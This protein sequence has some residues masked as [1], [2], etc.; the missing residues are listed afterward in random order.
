MF[1]G[2]AWWGISALFGCS[3]YVAVVD[4]S[5]IV[6]RLVDDAFNKIRINSSNNQK[7]FFKLQLNVLTALSVHLYIY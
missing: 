4:C 5:R 6:Q 7:L 2:I 1:G 3:I